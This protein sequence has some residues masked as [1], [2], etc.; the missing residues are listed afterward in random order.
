MSGMMMMVILTA[1]VVIA[2]ACAASYFFGKKMSRPIVML[3]GVSEK[4]AKGDTNV[5]I[6]G[7]A[8]CR[9]ILQE[10]Q[11]YDVSDRAVGMF[12]IICIIFTVVYW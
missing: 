11:Y 3:T 1:L 7:N 2:L 9:Y 6:I 5:E 10:L 12:L 8:S 4:L